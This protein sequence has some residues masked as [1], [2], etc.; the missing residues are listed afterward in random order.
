MKYQAFISYKH[1]EVSRKQAVALEKALKK[2]AKP[3][4]KPHIKIFRDEKVSEDGTAK[5]IGA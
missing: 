1:S 4:L 3:L 2:Y 5:I